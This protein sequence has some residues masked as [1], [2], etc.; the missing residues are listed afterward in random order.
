MEIPASIGD[1]ISQL[2]K[3]Q[4]LKARDQWIRPSYDLTGLKLLREKAGRERDVRELYRNR[5]PYELLQNA[6]DVRAKKAIFVLTPEGLGFAH[7]GEWFSVVN[8]R[9]LADG[10]SD[11]DPKQ[12]IGHKGLGFRSVL[13]ITPAPHIMK[14]GGADFF[15][16]KFTWA[17]NNGHIQETFRRYPHLVDEYRQWTQYGQS[18]CP[19][20]A[21]P[22][23]ARRAS[24]GTGA[25]VYDELVRGIHYG[26]GFTTMF[27]FPAR[28]PDADPRV[29]ED[30]G[31]SPLVADVGSRDRLVH[32]IE[33]E[34]STLLPFLSCLEEVSLHLDRQLLAKA[35]VTG[36][37][38]SQ[39]GDEVQVQLVAETRRYEASFFQM[40]GTS[41]IPLNVKSDPQTPRA[42]RQMDTANFRL[43]IRLEDGRPV[44]DSSAKF[45]VYF[46]TDEPTGFG[47]TVHG[48]FFVKP[49]RTRLMSGDYNNWLLELTAKIFAGGLLTRL[50]KRYDA[51]SIFESLRPNL[52]VSYDTAQQYQGLVA[53]ALRTRGTP[54]V[55][56][57]LGLLLHSQVA[58]PTSVDA[59]GFWDAKF[60]DSVAPVTGK[61]AFLDPDADSEDARKFLALADVHP[62]GDKVILDLL[63]DCAKAKPD[64]NW[65]YDVYT[66]LATNKQSA[67]WNH[68]KVAGRCILPDQ[69]LTVIAVPREPSPVLCL[70][71]TDDASIPAVPQCFRS[72]FVFLNT[73]LSRQLYEGSE[74]VRDWLVNTCRMA[75]FEATDL[76][77]RAIAA[78]V[79]KFYVGTIKLTQNDLASL[80]EFLR[81]IIALSRSIKSEQFWQDVGRLPVPLAFNATSGEP[82]TAGGMAPAFLCYWQDGDP[83]CCECIR[84][85]EG[86]RRLS[87]AFV[88]YL[89]NM[90]GG[91][92]REWHLLFKQAGVSGT[93]KRLRYVRPIG[94]GREVP[95]VPQIPARPDEAAFSGERQR[96]ENLV[97]LDNLRDTTLWR[98]HVESFSAEER[99]GCAL[100]EVSVVDQIDACVGVAEA[101]WRTNQEDS[102]ERMWSIVRSIPINDT[103]TVASDQLFRRSRGGGGSNITIRGFLKMQIG[104]LRW[105]PSSFGP[106]SPSEGF[107]RFANRR[108]VS[109]GFSQDEL[110]DLL[111]P[112]VVAETLEDYERLLRLGFEALEEAGASPNTLVRF[113]RISGERLAESWARESLLGVRSRWRLVRGAIQECYR[114]LN[115]A[116]A[117]APFPTG[118][119]LGAKFSSRVE[120]R[121]CPLY[122]AEPGSA[123]ERAFSETLPLIDADRVYQ[124]LFEKLGIKRLIAGQSV[125]EEFCGDARSVTSST[126]RESIVSELGPYLLA[127]V[128]AKCEDKGHRELVLRRLRERFDVQVTDRLTINYTLH[129]DNGQEAIERSINFPR[130]YLRRRMVE[131]A[132]AVRETHY[133]LY[134]VSQDDVVPLFEL[135]GDALGDV[136]APV[137]FDGTRDDRSA[138]FPRIVSRFQNVGGSRPAMEQ[139]LLE[140][141]G[142]S[143]EAQ[144]LAED[145]ITGRTDDVPPIEVPPPPAIFVNPPSQKSSPVDR[146]NGKKL[147]QHE[148]DAS[149]QL[150]RL[151]KGLKKDG[152]A[153]KQD[154]D[155]TAHGGQD[156]AG[157]RITRAQE[158]RGRK[159]EEEFLRRIKLPGG[160][161]GFALSKD[162]RSDDTG[163]DFACVQ[164]GRNVSVEVKTFTRDG[165]IIITANELKAAAQYQTD[166]YLIGFV[167]DGPEPQWRS[168]I[169]Q[170][171]LPHLLENGKFDVD[172]KLQ[173][174]A[175]EVFSL[176]AYGESNVG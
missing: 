118:M 9:S 103:K 6:D 65:W 18:A 49:D 144:G 61:S 20:M 138:F 152:D 171:P 25:A 131:A 11:K 55:P 27:W 37:R 70:S 114:A 15:G 32:F 150:N 54:F 78:T 173:A 36:N 29:I 121:A 1:R 62:L 167:D 100:Q 148:Q 176:E 28:D 108:F 3:A 102:R 99:E 2:D 21:I 76:L 157:N 166:Y 119:R 134:V 57:R 158:A 13:D 91:T 90:F 83:D 168:C 115:Q 41:P 31:V 127:V 56:S 94:G 170:N 141:L 46:P 72:S 59:E 128:I 43:S 5:A 113:L 68:D 52:A 154:G 142:V 51:K 126:L 133:S 50:L 26:A 42:V 10:W 60:T 169:L 124:L 40:H 125:S 162:T 4:F 53:Q 34:V 156:R 109:R 110:G 98:E 87:A 75:D 155:R 160:W 145:D 48:D 88:T 132:G 81:K 30:L 130:F 66:H 12:C 38:K 97:V 92:E 151:I 172:V 111:V 16:F 82:L 129:A 149:E 89:A 107:L 93:P 67:G 22:G 117:N 45:H 159:G 136:L 39:Y 84:G 147:D 44:F 14:V 120:F 47:F 143:L 80:W 161:M 116:D 123:L 112:Y 8:F 74:N 71:P 7:D 19:V 96:D 175:V 85:V 33:K 23:E 139:F 77:P 64:A 174:K 86:Y 73:S 165:R 101:A 24:M 105:A 137:F 79:R 122:Y 104:R 35:T 69:D 17:L 163:Y 95:F 106:V 140:S 153:E 63:E 164:G 135:D 146:T 58:L